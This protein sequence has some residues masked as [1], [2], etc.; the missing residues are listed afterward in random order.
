MPNEEFSFSSSGSDL[1]VEIELCEE[2]G[3]PLGHNATRFYDGYVE[4]RLHI[5]CV[6]EG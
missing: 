1:A 3:E 5:A 4:R 6:P 2:C